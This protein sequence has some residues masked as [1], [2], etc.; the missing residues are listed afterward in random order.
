MKE[1]EKQQGGRDKWRGV[2]KINV[3]EEELV[4]AFQIL[5]FLRASI[6]YGWGL[7]DL[8]LR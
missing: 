7:I 8:L 5:L 3:R 4:T 6:V 2:G 1:E